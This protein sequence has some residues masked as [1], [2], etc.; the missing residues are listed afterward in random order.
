[1]CREFGPSTKFSTHVQIASV[2]PQI[3]TMDIGPCPDYGV[4]V[5]PPTLPP[6]QNP[7]MQIS[8]L[9]RR[10]HSAEE[11]RRTA[12]RYSPEYYEALRE[13]EVLARE[14][15][16]AVQAESPLGGRSIPI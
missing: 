4:R 11:R 8:G 14:L 13:L 15:W 1:M 3:P 12:P 9:M 2:I 10:L 16:K 7:G 5:M 6:G